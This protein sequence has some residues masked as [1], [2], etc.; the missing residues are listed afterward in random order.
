MEEK[1]TIAPA[2]IEK[3]RMMFLYPTLNMHG[4]QQ[5]SCKGDATLMN[6]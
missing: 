6:V 4:S 1:Q 2:R 3:D 5:I